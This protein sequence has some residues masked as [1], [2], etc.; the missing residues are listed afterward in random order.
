MVAI[1]KYLTENGRIPRTQ[2]GYP[3]RGGI[4]PL[5]R[6]E[7]IEDKIQLSLDAKCRIF[8]LTKEEDLKD[9]TVILDKVA[10]GLFTRLSIDKE[11]EKPDGTGWLVLCR[12]AEIQGD[13]PPEL[14]KSL[15]VY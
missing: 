7:E 3:L 8:D 4:D 14:L 11:M 13:V 10:N 15:G 1:L 6:P 2:D 5:L 9:Y 12:W